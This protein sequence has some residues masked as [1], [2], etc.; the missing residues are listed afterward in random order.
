MRTSIPLEV[1]LRDRGLP[2]IDLA[3][4]LRT[5]SGRTGQRGLEQTPKKPSTRTSPQERVSSET[6]RSLVR[7]FDRTRSEPESLSEAGLPGKLSALSETHLPPCLKGCF[8]RL[9]MIKI[10]IVCCIHH[11]RSVRVTLW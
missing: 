9:I 3:A 2:L 5:G 10:S 8:N 6:R 7:E 11:A 1:P 4:P